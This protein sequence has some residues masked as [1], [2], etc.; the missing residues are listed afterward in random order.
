MTSRKKRG[1]NGSAAA[2]VDPADPHIALRPAPA[3]AVNALIA[4]GI[5]PLAARVLA[6]RGI[7]EQAQI[8]PRLQ[9]L[10]QSAQLPGIQQ[11]AQTLAAACQAKERIGI[12]GDYD[13]DGITATALA[14]QCLRQL[15][16]DVCWTIPKRQEGYGLSVA[17]ADAQAALGVRHLLTVDN[18]TTAH[19][20]IARAQELGI[21]VYITDHHQPDRQPLSADQVVN[22][23]LNNGGY[24]AFDNLTGVG[25]AF[26]LMAQ[27]RRELGT[28]LDMKQYLDLVALGTI[29]DVAVMDVTNRTLCEAG[30]ARMRNEKTSHG[31]KALAAAKKIRLAYTTSRDVGFRFAPLLNAAGRM[32]EAEQALHCLLAENPAA[33]ETQAA[34][35]IELNEQ[36]LQCQT[37]VLNEAMQQIKQPA[38]AVVVYAAHWYPGVV[39]IVAGR[40]TDQY[41][42]PTVVFHQEAGGNWRGSVRAPTGYDVIAIIQALAA[43]HPA[44]FVD[45][46]GHNRAAGITLRHEAIETFSRLFAAADWPQAARAAAAVTEVDALDA[47]EMTEAAQR[48]LRYIAWGNGFPE[49]LYYGEF[50]LLST[51]PLGESSFLRLELKEQRSGKQ[52]EAVYFGA[53]PLDT[54]AIKV[55]YRAEINS[56][57]AKVR[58]TITSVLNH[59]HTG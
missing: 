43:A 35:L 29:A 24:A 28:D 13:V 53:E 40:I 45:W 18:G 47:A 3:P 48:Q 46:G 20:G 57:N 8:Y 23:Q 30:L 55:L 27:L 49:P 4:Q 16:A 52:F 12:V 31:V 19:R 10:P 2:K 14:Y 58:L 54:A 37:V 44:L 5:E 15:G 34:R 39:G 21:R 1:T 33:A 6:A 7:S 59:R 11:L 42:C 9:G 17:I 38:A 32:G 41:R 26:Y 50:S 56:Y 25:I 22:P 36:R 51:T